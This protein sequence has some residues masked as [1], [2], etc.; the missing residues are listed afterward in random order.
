VCPYCGEKQESLKDAKEDKDGRKSLKRSLLFLL[1][2]VGIAVLIVVIILGAIFAYTRVWPP[3]VVIES[4]SMQHDDGVSYIGVIDTGDLV[5][6][7]SAPQ[8]SDITTWVEGK[9][10][11]YQ[12]YSNYGDVIIFKKLN[13]ETPIIHRPI[14]WM[15]YNPATKKFNITSLES[16]A[17]AGLW[18]GTYSNLTPVKVPRNLDGNIWI[19]DSGW[20]GNLNIT[21]RIGNSFI[22][23]NLSSPRY[24]RGGYVT[25]GDNNAYK[26]G[27][28]DDYLVR[29]EDVYGK[30][31]GELPWFGLIKL[32]LAPSLGV[33]C[34][35]WG[36]P[37]AP[38][39]SWDS[40]V[41]SLVVII[42]AP[43]ALD[44][45][46]ALWNR[47]KLKR[48]ESEKGEP[49]AEAP[50]EEMHKISPASKERSSGP[51]PDVGPD[52]PMEKPPPE[53]K[54]PSV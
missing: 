24:Q 3:M 38:R 26:G 47:R 8:R 33:C 9:A 32:T 34:T 20:R 13:Y 50:V 22:G 31:R 16:P 11:G 12:T 1:R 7:Q 49:E 25:L 15:D 23:P 18:G 14:F 54:K 5:L 19:K 6:V 30:A 39:N 46:F 27:G 10:I 2:D 4:N 53:P 44:I 48:A 17:M 35:G 21:F 40:L 29:Q 43:I 42:V 41:I 51:P 37:R 45:S 52:T 28:Y 36:D